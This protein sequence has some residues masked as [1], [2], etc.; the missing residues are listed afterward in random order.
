[1][2]GAVIGT[3]TG[4]AI[5]PTAARTMA[6]LAWPTEEAGLA[7]DPH[8]QTRG[9]DQGKEPDSLVAAWNGVRSTPSGAPVAW[10][11]TS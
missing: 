5:A 1:M 9:C 10:L 3:V 11:I 7:S 2:V 6:V 4:G 8:Q